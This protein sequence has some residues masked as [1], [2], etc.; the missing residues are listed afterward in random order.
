MCSNEIKPF[1]LIG[2]IMAGTNGSYK[3]TEITKDDLERVAK[4]QWEYNPEPPI[5]IVNQND[6]EYI[7]YLLGR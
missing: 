2:S 7:N 5:H 1:D 6:H 3:P 4:L